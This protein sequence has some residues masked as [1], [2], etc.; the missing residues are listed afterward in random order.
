MMKTQRRERE[1]G[2]SEFEA[3]SSE[4]EAEA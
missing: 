3:G 2:R 1:D 4:L